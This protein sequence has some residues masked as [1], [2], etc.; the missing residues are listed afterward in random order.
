MKS[1]ISGIACIV[2]MVLIHNL[3]DIPGWA[4]YI[5]LFLMV[6]GFMI[7]IIEGLKDIFNK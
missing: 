7:V 1:L 3:Q 5:G 6:G 2:G 4:G